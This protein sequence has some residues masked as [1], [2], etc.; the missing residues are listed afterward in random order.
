MGDPSVRVLITGGTGLLGQ[1]LLATAGEGHQITLLHRRDYRVRTKGAEQWVLDIVNQNKLIDFMSTHN[2]DVVI[3][4]AGLANVDYVESHSEEGWQSNVVGTQNIVDVV[5]KRKIRL[6]YVSTNA[7]F[8]GKCAPYKED[9][10]TNPINRY[11]H[12]KVKC[13]EIVTR[14]C[15]EAIITRPILM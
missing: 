2:F 7:V 15:P 11:G 12:I 9:D 3:H 4:A 8:D 5:L 1:A 13:E 6:V 10:L 14:M